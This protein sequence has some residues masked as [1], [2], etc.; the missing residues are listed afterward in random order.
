MVKNPKLLLK[1][2]QQEKA[3]LNELVAQGEVEK[4]EEIKQ[5]LAWQK[6]FDKTDG[7]KVN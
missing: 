3:Q 2:I 4:A 1:K 6:A 5:N 7:K